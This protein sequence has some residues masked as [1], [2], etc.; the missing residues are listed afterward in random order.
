MSV[1]LLWFLVVIYMFSILLIENIYQIQV[2]YS[3]KVNWYYIVLSDYVVDQNCAMFFIYFFDWFENCEINYKK[4]HIW[5]QKRR[6]KVLNWWIW[7]GFPIQPGWVLPFLEIQGYSQPK[8]LPRHIYRNDGLVVFK[9][10]KSLKEIKYWLE[11]FQKTVNIA[12]G[13]QHLQFNAEIWVTDANFLLPAKE[14]KVQ[15]VTND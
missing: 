5:R 9:G 2:G 4:W 3:D 6:T 10:K 13:N 11:V 14:E 15:V 12:A 1:V 7:I 8:N